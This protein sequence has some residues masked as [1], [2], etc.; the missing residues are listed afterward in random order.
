MAVVPGLLG[1]GAGSLDAES[2]RGDPSA[3]Q[4][5]AHSS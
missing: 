2:S 1:G 3:S 5:R 4:Q